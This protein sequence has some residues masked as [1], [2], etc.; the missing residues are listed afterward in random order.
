[1]ASLL[2]KLVDAADKSDFR[3][4]QKEFADQTELILRKGVYPYKYFDSME[5]F[6][7][8]QLPPID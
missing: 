2:E 4:T 8:T 3:L 1:M 6:N 7:E 5:R